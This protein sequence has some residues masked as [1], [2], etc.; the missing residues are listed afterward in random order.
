MKKIFVKLKD[1]FISNVFLLPSLIGVLIFFVLPFVIVIAYSLVDNPISLNFVFLDNYKALL[2]N[3]AFKLAAFNTFIFFIISVPLVIIIPLLL[4]MYFTNNV[5]GKIEFDRQTGEKKPKKSWLKIFFLSPMM[6]PIA[7]TILIWN[8]IFYQ[9]GGINEFLSI[10]GIKSIEWM[11]SDYG[12][13]VIVLLFLWKNIG[14]NMILFIA[15]LSNVPKELLEAASIDG[16]SNMQ[17]FTNIKLRYLSPTLLFVSIISVINSFK[18]FREIYLLT[19]NYPYEALYSLQHFMNNTFNSLDYQKLSAA[20][21]ITAIVVMIIVKILFKFEY[22]LGKDLDDYDEDILHRKASLWVKLKNR[23]FSA[24]FKKNSLKKY[25][26]KSFEIKSPK[27]SKQ[28]RNKTPDNWHRFS[29]LLLNILIYALGVFFL[30]PILLTVTNSFMST[31]EIMRNYG[32]ILD[33]KTASSDINIFLNKTVTLKFIPD[34]VSGMQYNQLL[35]KTPEYLLKFW[36]SVILVVPIALF[37]IFVACLASY[38]FARSNKRWKNVVFFLYMIIM[39][40]P[41][42]VTLVPNYFVSEWLGL[43]N[44][45]MAVILPGVFSTFSI[46]ILT[47][48][49]RRIPKVLTEAAKLDGAGNWQIFSKIYVPI[50]R[51]II[52]SV[53][54]LIFIDYWNMIELPLILLSDENKYPLS[55]FLSK[56]NTGDIGLAFAAATIYM[57]PTILV[58]AY[59]EDELENGV[60]YS[61]DSK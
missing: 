27:I 21:I 30:L 61:G 15:G 45:R 14:Y 39:I 28:K 7:S 51:G 44:K 34:M 23:F 47:K 25:R 46:F 56:I 49:M 42:Q 57:I 17:K 10:F 29:R 35:I 2:A 50:C 8:I 24:D 37:Q 1:R 52:F 55:I 43:L 9:N 36:N 33:A 11:K 54:I 4:A 59:G 53:F 13:F 26:K 12:R 6:V 5:G 16:A 3:D 19:G 40:M 58:F 31:S 48:Y 20:A 18:I 60:M 32:S 38:D 41:Y 22:I